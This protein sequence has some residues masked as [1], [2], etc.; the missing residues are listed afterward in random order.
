MIDQMSPLPGAEIAAVRWC[1]DQA[2]KQ[3]QGR[4]KVSVLAHRA[5]PLGTSSECYYMKVV[6][7]SK[8]RDIEIT[9]IWYE[10]NPPLHNLNSDRPLPARLR[11][12]ETFETWVP[13][14]A[15][16]E[17][18]A[19]NVEQLGCVRLSSGKVAKSRLNKHVPPIGYVGGAGNTG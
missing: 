5:A 15:L 17:P 10:T 11:P 3:Q 1:V 18:D 19:P 14:A 13:V 4:R 8:D 7:L 16:P 6:N 12:D 9:H 2:R